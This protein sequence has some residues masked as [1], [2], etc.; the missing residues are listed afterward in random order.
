MFVDE[1]ELFVRG[2]RGGNGAVSF[3]REKYVPK[4][5]PDGG[6]GGDGGSVYFQADPSRHSFLD[7]SYR[8]TLKAGDGENGRRKNQH[9]ARG[10]DLFVY[11]PPGTLIRDENGNILADLTSADQKALVAR[12][13]KSGKGNARFASSRRR[14]P[15]LAEKGLPGEEKTIKLELKLMAQVGLVGLP[16]AGKSTLLSRISA[17]K[18][19]VDSYPFT[20]LAPNLGM[21]KVGDEGS[22]I[23]ADLPGLI[24]GAHQGAGLGHR[25]LRHIERNLLLLFLIDLSPGV[26][27]G[28]DESYSLLKNELK[29]YSKLLMEYPKV[30]AGNKLDLTGAEEQLKKLRQAVIKI[31]GQ[32]ISVFGISAAT[33]EGLDELVNFLFQKVNEIAR[34]SSEVEEEEEIRLDQS[35]EK[36]LKVEIVDGV[37]QVTGT[38]VERM[39]A[40]TDFENE[41]AL[42][43]FQNF[44]RK[45]GLDKELKNKGIEEGDTVRIGGEEFYFYE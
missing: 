7:L 18:P 10:K 26:E 29:A 27:P 4:G 11:V 30:V 42:H 12:G 2:G 22:F 6:D 35:A 15:R 24:E 41:E 25:F 37:F 36:P 13:G 5:G 9:G 14:A 23:V 38:A 40:K 3:R 34:E 31:E 32:D 19:K 45:V 44:T 39:A 1:L 20:T 16:N 17:A 43:R 28:P 21:V 8:R 33:G